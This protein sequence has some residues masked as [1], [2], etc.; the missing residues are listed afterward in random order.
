MA[1]DYGTKRVGLAVTDPL[2]IIAT[3]LTTVHANEAINF[4]VNYIAKENVEALVVGMPVTTSG[5]ASKVQVQLK[6]FLKKLS[7]VVNIP[8]YHVDER[9]TSKLALDALIRSGV[10]KMQRQNKELIDQTS[11]AI[12]L[13]SYLERKE[14]KL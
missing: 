10:K 4:I 13:Q 14:N 7:A 6:I 9:F 8:I 2:Q 5:E 3:P 11:A 1:I 12:I